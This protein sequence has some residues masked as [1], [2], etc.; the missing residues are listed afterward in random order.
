MRWGTQRTIPNWPVGVKEGLAHRPLASRQ[1]KDGGLTPA[2]LAWAVSQMSVSE[3]GA[4]PGDVPP[5][6]LERYRLQL[7]DRLLVLARPS[8]DRGPENQS[9]IR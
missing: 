2:Q 7:I 4:I 1:R 8:S 9:R 6:D 5:A 3:L